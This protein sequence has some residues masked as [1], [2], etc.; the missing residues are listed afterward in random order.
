[1]S[2]QEIEQVI[3][4][5]RTDERWA[6]V[7]PG[8][9][10]ATARYRH[11]VAEKRPTSVCGTTA[12]PVTLWRGNRTKPVCPACVARYTAAAEDVAPLADI[13]RTVIQRVRSFG[14]SDRRTQ[15]TRKPS[16][17]QRREQTRQAIRTHLGLNTPTSAVESLFALVETGVLDFRID[18]WFIDADGAFEDDYGSF[19]QDDPATTR[20]VSRGLF[21]TAVSDPGPPSPTVALPI[22]DD[23]DPRDNPLD[24]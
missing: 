6:T 20:K 10:A 7:A 21:T 22:T 8:D 5:L 11:I 19:R 2:A 3:P 14:T 15:V 16:A 9:D 13:E 1:M 18:S 4:T 12:L 24:W 17:D 23:L